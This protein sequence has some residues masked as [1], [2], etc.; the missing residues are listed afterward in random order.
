[1]TLDWHD[2]NA[3]WRDAPDFNLDQKSVD[4]VIRH[5][6]EFGDELFFDR[7]W[8][9]IGFTNRETHLPRLW[10]HIQLTSV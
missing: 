7:I 3:V 9:S 1:M 5:R 10:V 6:K 4:S 8:R 2:F